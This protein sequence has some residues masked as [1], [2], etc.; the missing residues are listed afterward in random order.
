MRLEGGGILYISEN[1]FILFSQNTG[2]FTNKK[3][4]YDYEFSFN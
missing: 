1:S 4:Y 3:I 2:I